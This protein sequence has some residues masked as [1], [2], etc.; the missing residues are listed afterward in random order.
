M[1]KM[2][3]IALPVAILLLG[4]GSAYA[5]TAFETKTAEMQGYFYN[6]SAPSEK[7]ILTEKR[8]SPVIGAI[9]TWNDG[10]ENHELFQINNG[11]SCVSQLYEIQ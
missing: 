10:S 4:A 1:K 7:C 6:E 5:G 11:T 2:R 8:C 9:C 3:K